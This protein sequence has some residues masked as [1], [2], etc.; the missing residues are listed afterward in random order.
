MPDPNG[1]D[2]ATAGREVR[3]WWESPEVLGWTAL[4]I[5]LVLSLFF[6]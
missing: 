5:T 4:G 3:A 6:L 1:P 2:V